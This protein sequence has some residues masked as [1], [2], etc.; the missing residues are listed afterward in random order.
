[1]QRIP[2]TP[3]SG[4][5]QKVEALGFTFHSLNDLYWDESA[6]YLLSEQEVD[7][8]EEATEELW[9][10][11]LEAVDFIIHKKRYRDFALNPAFIPLVERSWERQDPSVY[12]RFDFTFDGD[13]PKLLEFNA[14]TPTSLFESSVV[15]W[16]WLE[17]FAPNKDQFNSIH[18]KLVERWGELT[19]LQISHFTCIAD[20]LEDLTTTEYLRDT[21]QQ[22]GINAEFIYLEDIGWNPMTKRFVDLQEKGISG[23]FK[24]YPFEWLCEDAFAEGMLY[25]ENTTKWIEPAWKALLSNKAILPVL[26]ELFPE[27]PNLLPSFFENQKHKLGFEYV[28]K[29]LLSREGANITLKGTSG[30]IAETSGEYGRE[31]YVY[32]KLCP[33]P[34][35]NGNYPLVGSWLI[36]NQSAGIGIRESNSL[37]T[38]NMSRFV[39]HLFE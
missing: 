30:I 13:T 14:D 5:Q 19:H 8:L 20:H 15:Q 22:A 38:D 24:L 34:N 7:T 26:W 21:A 27:H 17:D 12:G 33:L 23:I 35:F 39:P 16:Y 3:R 1:M 25:T 37:I 29:P 2:C 32:Q 4:W 36:G 31:G 18:E 11:C 28:R 9:K 10:C 6:H